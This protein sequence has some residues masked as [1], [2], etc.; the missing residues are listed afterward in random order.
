MCKKYEMTQP[1]DESKCHNRHD[2]INV[3][4]IED[5]LLGGSHRS[6]DDS[7]RPC[8]IQFTYSLS[9]DAGFVWAIT[10]RARAHAVVSESH[11]LGVSITVLL[12][13]L[14]QEYSSSEPSAPSVCSGAFI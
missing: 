5:K 8:C 9:P 4:E 7:A 2:L 11:D 3:K 1:H 12:E 14:D 10:D 6:T 13:Y